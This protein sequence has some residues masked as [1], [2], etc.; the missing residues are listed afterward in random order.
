MISTLFQTYISTVLLQ[1]RE[2]PGRT[3][4]TLRRVSA[5][6]SV[7]SMSMSMSMSIPV[8]S[9][10]VGGL[11][12]ERR[13]AATDVD[14]ITPKLDVQSNMPKAS[15]T[16]AKAK[17]KT[18]GSKSVKTDTIDATSGSDSDTGSGSD[19]EYIATIFACSS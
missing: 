12:K 15:E 14:P 1:G 5:P 19:S 4:V 16:K 8:S 13:V 2:D 10:D 17:I 18:K 6:M 7:M 11:E 9:V 3:E